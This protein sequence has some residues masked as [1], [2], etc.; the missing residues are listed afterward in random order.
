[1]SEALAKGRKWL[2]GMS[3]KADF[4][5]RVEALQLA[6]TIGQHLAVD[7]ARD[8]SCAALLAAAKKVNALYPLHWERVDGGAIIM[9]ERIA[10]FEEAFSLL[11]DAI[12]GAAASYPSG[13]RG[14][15]A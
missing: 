3:M 10:Q 8:K 6:A 12:N 15:E 9:P 11:N 2:H 14:A 1:M 13:T 7:E 4:P 5:G